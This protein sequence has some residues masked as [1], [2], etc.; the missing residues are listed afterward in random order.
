MTRL[1]KKARDIVAKGN[2]NETKRDTVNKIKKSL[3]SRV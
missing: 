3:P 1:T 2:P